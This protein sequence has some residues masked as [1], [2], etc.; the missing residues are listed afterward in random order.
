MEEDL[1]ALSRLAEAR[2]EAFGEGMRELV[3]RRKDRA[4]EERREAEELAR[5]LEERERLRKAAEEEDNIRARKGAALKKKNERS[6]K[7][8]ERPLT[9][10]AHGLARQDGAVDM[11]PKGTFQIRIFFKRSQ[12]LRRPSALSQKVHRIHFEKEHPP[13]TSH[14]AK[15]GLRAVTT[16]QVP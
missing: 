15:R 14:M 9:H 10:G 6:S 5:E 16:T 8:E 7:P 2:S 13:P 1:R 3:A 4:E 11:P 12:F